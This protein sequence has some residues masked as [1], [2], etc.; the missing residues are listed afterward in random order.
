MKTQML[1]NGTVID[2]L[3]AGTGLHCL[4]I[5]KKHNIGEESIIIFI[6]VPSNVMGKKDMI[7]LQDFYIDEKMATFLSLIAPNVTINI[8][9]K[10]TVTKK[11]KPALPDTIE[12][13][14]PCINS[15]CITNTEGYITEYDIKSK[16]PVILKCRYCEF[17]FTPG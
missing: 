1:E 11:I 14:I 7:K 15:R 10:H 9:H 16:Q 5:L 6:N 12:G 3:P 8:I 13:L 17:E 2:H 4:D